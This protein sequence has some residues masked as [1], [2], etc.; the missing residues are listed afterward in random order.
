MPDM[1]DSKYSDKLST[2][3]SY[4]ELVEQ[5]NNTQNIDSSQPDYA[6]VFIAF[7]VFTFLFLLFKPCREFAVWVFKDIVM[8]SLVWFIKISSLWLVWIFRHVVVSH[9]SFLKHLSTP[10]SVIFFNLDDQRSENDK[11]INRKAEH[12]SK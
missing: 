10:R 3:L 12:L 6:I 5:Q 7:C 2:D 9:V 4:Q 11:S 8:P 1:M